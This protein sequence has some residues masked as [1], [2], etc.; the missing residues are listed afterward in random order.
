MGA[1]HVR[2][3]S[4]D[5]AKA[6]LEHWPLL[7]RV[8]SHAAYRFPLLASIATAGFGQQ[9]LEFTT[10]T[11]VSGSNTEKTG[12]SAARI[13]DDQLWPLSTDRI[14]DNSAPLCVPSSENLNS[15]NMSTSVP[16]G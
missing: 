4:V 5:I 15:V 6:M 11:P 3:P 7:N 12:R 8:S 16:V 13:G 1:D 10:G 9:L 2:P 14:T